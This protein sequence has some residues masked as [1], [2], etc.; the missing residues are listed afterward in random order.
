VSD[1]SIIIISTGVLWS[2]ICV[3][4][5]LRYIGGIT[6][7]YLKLTKLLNHYTLAQFERLAQ[8]DPEATIEVN[9]GVAEQIIFEIEHKKRSTKWR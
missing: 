3:I 8:L 9:D 6:I 1:I 7:S 2:H 4:N 5:Y